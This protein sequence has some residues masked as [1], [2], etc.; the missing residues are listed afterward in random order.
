MAQDQ[1]APPRQWYWDRKVPIAFALALAAYFVGGV[2]WVSDV[3]GDQTALDRR[4][5]ILEAAQGDIKTDHTKI[6]VLEA[7]LGALKEQVERSRVILDE[8][9]T[10]LIQ[11]RGQGAP[12]KGK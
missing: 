4:V 9:R 11:E 5:T 3:E 10:L 12:P 2:R 1:E 7:S 8:I 6:A